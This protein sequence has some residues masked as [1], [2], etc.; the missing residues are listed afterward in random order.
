MKDRLRRFLIALGL[1]VGGVVL[2]S[3]LASAD[4]PAAVYIATVADEADPEPPAADTP[5]VALNSETDTDA[6]NL[7]PIL[8]TLI[9][10]TLIPLVNGIVT[11]ATT[12]TSVKTV[13]SLFLSAVA[14]LVT[15][16]IT[17]GGGAVIGEQAL[18]AAAL[19]FITQAAMYLS[20]WKPLE[21]TSSP[22]TKVD[23]NG[24]LVTVPGKLSTVGVK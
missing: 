13:L 18:V 15:V 24:V 8:V 21:V 6:F 4:A 22:V 2:P 20:L 16:A 12:S 5:P 10:G 3:A 23:E 9:L 19:T 17:P 7:S 1:V 11:K 14:G